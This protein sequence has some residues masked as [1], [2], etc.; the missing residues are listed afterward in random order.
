MELYNKDQIELLEAHN[1]A[2][3]KSWFSKKPLVLDKTLNEY[4][5]NWATTM[6]SKDRLYHSSMSDIL[7]LGFSRAGENIAWGQ[8]SSEEV[9]RSWMRSMGHRANI[10]STKFTKMGVGIKERDGKKYWCVVFAA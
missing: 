8:E 10:L 4:A 6:A 7:S 3:S 2:R 5:M 9:M 1:V